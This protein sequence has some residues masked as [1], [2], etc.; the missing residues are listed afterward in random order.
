M[1]K[2]ALVLTV[3]A[4]VAGNAAFAQTGRG[5]KASADTGSSGM[6]WGIGLGGLAVLGVVVGVTASSAAST[7]STFSH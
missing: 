4:T 7:P 3:L 1:K 5:A 6:A 2:F